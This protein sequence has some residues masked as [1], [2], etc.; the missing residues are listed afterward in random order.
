MPLL[1]LLQLPVPPPS[2]FA[3]TGNVPLAV[4]SLAVATEVHNLQ[5]DFGLKTDII[6][7]S[8]TDRAGDEELIQNIVEKDPDFLGVSLYLWNSERSLYISE[9][10]KK[11]NPRTKIIIGGPE[12]CSDNLNL[13]EKGDF[14]F[15][16][17]GEAEHIFPLLLSN[18]LQNKSVESIPNLYYKTN[19]GSLTFSN[20]KSSPDFPL[21][22][23]KSPYLTG[24]LPV[25]NF[26]STYI[27]SVRGCKSQCTYCFYPK[28]S[29]VLRSIDIKETSD[30]L[31]H[32]KEKGAREIVFLDP[33]FN[34]RPSFSEFLDAI[35]DL[36]RDNQLKFFAEL[37]PEG[38][39][40]D[41]AK[42]LSRAG[43]YK[44]ELGMQSINKETLKRVKRFGSPEK[45]AEVSKI[46]T[47]EGIQ[48]LIDLIIG[49]PG[50]T[51]LDV[52]KGIEFFKKNNLDEWVQ[53]FILSVLPGTELRRTAV[54]QNIT[55][56]ITPPYRVIQTESFSN[57]Q[58]SESLLL[59]E[60]N[61]GHRLDEY[62][63]PMLSES[64]N[65]FDVLEI[66]LDN[67]KENNQLIKPGSRHFSLRIIGNNLYEKINLI[68]KIITSK[69]KIDPYCTLDVVIIP[70]NEFPLNLI[71]ELIIFLNS[72][73]SSYLSFVLTHRNENLKR[74]LVV[75]LK[76]DINYNQLWVKDLMY[77]VPVFID[78]SV[79]F[80]TQNIKKIGYELPRVRI[81]EDEIANIDWKKLKKC[82]GE[83]ITFKNRELE[84]KWNN[85]VLLY[86]D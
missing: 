66:D 13:L 20:Q 64:S 86:S 39:T 25:E 72:Q 40:I 11:R 65:Y 12:V 46:L 5:K 37:R 80:A 31:K 26:R 57:M 42:K 78:C 63:R 38:I 85:E 9:E 79:S 41:I 60:E 81:L 59:A 10:I 50:D 82:D 1:T 58:L 23:Y 7:P 27:E 35:Y 54:E 75:L 70:K 68:K 17:E 18:L 32:L 56:M 22:K 14:D 51:P 16:L 67:F 29:N 4:A 36:N 15:A 77:D 8:V 53:A 6:L 24:H 49:L 34:H 61:L 2:A 33:T 47:G 30:L 74:R 21:S 69:I 62:P 19:N 48:L 44:L 45:V 83:S 71:D 52:E 55:Y 43:F 73:N 28:S 76:N 84:K 3:E